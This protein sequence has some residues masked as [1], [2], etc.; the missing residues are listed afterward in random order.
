MATDDDDNVDV[1]VDVD[2][3]DDDDCF[4]F[5]QWFRFKSNPRVL[6]L[7]FSPLDLFSGFHF[8]MMIETGT[9]QHNKGRR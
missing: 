7:L 6:D 1:N 2:G 5:P 3:E 9:P 8:K 4:L